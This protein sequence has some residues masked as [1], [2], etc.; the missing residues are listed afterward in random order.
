MLVVKTTS[1][2]PVVRVVFSPDGTTIAVAQGHTGVTLLERATGQVRAQ[3]KLPRVADYAGVTFCDGNRR[4]IV[5]TPKGAYLFDTATGRFV[6]HEGTSWITSTVFTECEGELIAA[7]HRGVRR[8][9][10][11]TDPNKRLLLSY[12]RPPTDRVT[13]LALSPCGRW[14]FGLRRGFGVAYIRPVL[15]DLASG[16]VAGAVDHPPRPGEDFNPS[17]VFSANG[18]RFAVCD[19]AD[20]GVYDTAGADPDADPGPETDD[21]PSL[22]QRAGGTAIAPKPAAVIQPLF[23]LGRP[24]GVASTER[25][26]PPVA[27]TADGRGLLVRRPRNRI[28]L[29]DVATGRTLNEWSWR[30][31]WVTCLAVAP[32]G[33]T[34][35]AGARRGHVVLWDLE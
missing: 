21:H 16:H 23:R 35:A 30:L 20:V 27:L 2:H 34:A 31:D 29:W 1:P 13:V 12:G 10:I 15:L 7:G 4:L 28:Q 17:V 5:G 9:V 3:A 11:P 26:Q 14:G 6:A 25:W 33:L 18:E 24:E 19:G 32:D 22:V 8:V